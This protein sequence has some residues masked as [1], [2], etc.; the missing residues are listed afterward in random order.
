LK[1]VISGPRAPRL[2]SKPPRSRAA[3]PRRAPPGQQALAGAPRRA[4]RRP[5]SRRRLARPRLR[6]ARGR[7]HH[8]RRP[9][10]PK[11][12]RRTEA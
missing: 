11:S 7:R 1:I 3:G 2:D 9:D 5:A 6:P 10:Y 8:H 12:G 4:A